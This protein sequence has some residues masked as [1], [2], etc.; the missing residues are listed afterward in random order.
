MRARYMWYSSGEDSPAR[1][2]ARASMARFSR[3]STAC[4]VTISSTSQPREG[5][6]R[7]FP[8]SAI[9][10]TAL[11][12]PARVRLP[13][14]GTSRSRMRDDG[15][16]DEAAREAPAL[17]DPAQEALPVPQATALEDF[18]EHDV[19]RGRSDVTHAFEI[20]EPA[21]LRDRQPRAGEAGGD[22]GAEILRGIVGQEPVHVSR[23]Q[24]A[25]RHNASGRLDQG[26]LD[27]LL[28]QQ[29]DI[30]LQGKQRF[31][32]AFARR[33]AQ[34]AAKGA[35]RLLFSAA[36]HANGQLVRVREYVYPF[37][38]QVEPGSRRGLEEERAGAV[39][40]HPAQ[41][42]FFE[43]EPGPL[44]QRLRVGGALD[45]VV[46][47]AQAE[48]SDLRSGDDGVARVAGH[49]R[50]PAVLQRGGAGNAYAR[51]GHDLAHRHAELPVNHDRMVG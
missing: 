9:A 23:G 43:A 21:L 5:T 30:L 16:V 15:E 12:W 46:V 51:S 34:P 31:R 38:A 1:T 24:P 6:S 26:V 18:V 4:R 10:Y 49:H 39:G 35:V 42:V 25:V 45:F 2:R 13:S 27:D 3:S 7:S 47:G 17:R 8:S 32:L 33:I 50:H 22:G 37:H 44:L 19:D 29:F 14:W 11:R 36:V 28:V 40:Q 41:E 20:G 48:R